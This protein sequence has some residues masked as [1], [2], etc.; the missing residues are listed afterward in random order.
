LLIINLLDVAA[1]GLFHRAAGVV[2]AAKVQHFRYN[3]L[4]VTAL[5]LIAWSAFFTVNFRHQNDP[6]TPGKQHPYKKP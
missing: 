6:K 1:P 5:Y 4:N 2:N 3:N